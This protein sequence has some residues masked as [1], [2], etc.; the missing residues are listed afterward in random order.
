M[1]ANTLETLIVKIVT[2]TSEPLMT[3]TVHTFPATS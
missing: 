1:I 3:A 2:N